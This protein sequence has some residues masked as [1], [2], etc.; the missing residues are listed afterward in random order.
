ML[1]NVLDVL[2]L[3]LQIHSPLFYTLPCAPRVT[4]EDGI[5]GDPFSLVSFCVWP[6]GSPGWRWRGAGVQG[7]GIYPPGYHSPP[8]VS[9]ALGILSCPGFWHPLPLPIPLGLRQWQLCGYE[10]WAPVWFL[11]VSHI[12]PTLL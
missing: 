8:A 2:C 11:L 6:T 7:Q 4:S 10:L 9:F 1:F 5:R 3:A 12:L